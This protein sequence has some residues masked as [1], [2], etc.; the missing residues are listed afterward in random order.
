[1]AFVAAGG[2]LALTGFVAIGLSVAAAR[3]LALITSTSWV[4][5]APASYTFTAAQCAHWLAVQPTA[6]TCGAAAAMENSDDSSLFSL[7]G[8]IAGLILVGLVLAA[9]ALVRRPSATPRRRVP[10]LVVWAVGAT[11][12]GGAGV[13]LIAAGIGGAVVR[14]HWGQ[15]LWY[16]EGVVALL[17]GIYFAIRLIAATSR[18]L[19]ATVDR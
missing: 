5:G 16:V 4:Y 19:T 8:V 1:V 18:S 7:T 12:F 15:G 9:V 13:A 10:R 6:T 14:G 11:A 2:G 17:F 3:V